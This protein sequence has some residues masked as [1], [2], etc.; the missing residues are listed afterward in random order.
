MTVDLVVDWASPDPIALG[1][2]LADRLRLPRPD[3]AD[4]RFGLVLAGGVVRVA[5]SAPGGR[6]QLVSVSAI[7]EAPTT[8]G[9][10]DPAGVRL[11]GVAWA[12]VELAR[13]TRELAARFGL[14]A[15]AFRLAA[16]EAWLGAVSRAATLGGATLVAL[17]PTTEGRVAAALARFGEGPVAIYFELPGPASGVVRPGPLGPGALL[18]GSPAW[19]PFAIILAG[20]AAGRTAAGS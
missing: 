19:G 9:A 11:L 17:E 16:D 2:R 1:V 20:S 3:P 14:E 8:P 15:G 18:P 5:R 4:L 6:D 7:E 12:T 10:D 13:G